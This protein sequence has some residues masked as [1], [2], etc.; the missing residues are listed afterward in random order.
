MDAIL[1][2]FKPKYSKIYPTQYI[3]NRK[4]CKTEYE[5]Q[6]ILYTDFNGKINNK[7][8]KNN[9]YYPNS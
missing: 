2:I 3:G 5:S 7:R 1:K 4:R 9:S 8:T 6:D